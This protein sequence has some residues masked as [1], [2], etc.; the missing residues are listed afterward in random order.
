MK[1]KVDNKLLM[2]SELRN[3]SIR[4]H[5]R[6]GMSLKQGLILANS[7]GV[8]DVDYQQEIFVMLTNISELAVTIS[9]G[10]RIAQA[11]VVRNYVAQFELVESDEEPTPHSER[12]GGFGSTGV[13]GSVGLQCSPMSDDAIERVRSSNQTVAGFTRTKI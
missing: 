10:D 2:F 4:L 9:V 1:I 8:V 11:E 7:E 3:Y 5:A 6:S 13:T 12:S